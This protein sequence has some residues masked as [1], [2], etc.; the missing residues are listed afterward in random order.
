M[1]P[2]CYLKPQF[3]HSRYE[4]IEETVN[5]DI[6]CNDAI[7][8][9]QQEMWRAWVHESSRIVP[10]L[11]IALR[12]GIAA[13]RENVGRYLIVIQDETIRVSLSFILEC[14]VT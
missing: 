5:D 11:T 4:M 13:C 2:K 14:F 8:Y 3:P 1:N 9:L 10:P 12:K 6:S 7:N